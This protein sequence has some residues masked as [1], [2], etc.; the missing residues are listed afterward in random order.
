MIFA[1]VFALSTCLGFLQGWTVMCKMKYTLSSPSRFWVMRFIK[2]KKK[3]K[4]KKKNQNMKHLGNILISY[5]WGFVGYL[6]CS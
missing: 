1:Q 5:F 2:A 4:K 6:V 3:K